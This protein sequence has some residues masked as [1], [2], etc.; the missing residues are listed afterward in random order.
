MTRLCQTMG[1]PENLLDLAGLLPSWQLSM[2]A[3]RKSPKTIISYTD[4]VTKFLRWCAAND[5]APQLAKT[6]LQAFLAGLLHDGAAASSV[7][8]YR[9]GL[10]RY[11]SWLIEEGELEGP[12]PFDAIKPPKVDAKVTPALTDDQLRG[13]IKACHGKELRDRRDEAIVRLLTET[14][15]RA[16]E[17]IGLQVS[18]VNLQ[19]GQA[20]VFRGKGGKGRVVPF[21]PQTAAAIDRY[22]RTRHSHRLADTGQLWLGKGGQTFGYHGL[23][24]SLKARAEVAGIKGFHLHLLRHTAAT[25]WLR[26]GG[27]EQGLMS[28]AGWTKHDMLDRYTKASASERAAAESRTLN[29]GDL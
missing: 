20:V 19:T 11:A 6:T 13:L 1:M 17:L 24:V 16:A 4:G 21:S 28:I 9:T 27:T 10:R 8:A 18:D 23:D 7:A 29:L 26:A 12:N 3:E 25:R 15:L 5:T 14:G 22:L 2:R